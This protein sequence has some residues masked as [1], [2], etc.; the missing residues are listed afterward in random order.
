MPRRFYQRH[1]FDGSLFSFIKSAVL[2][3]FKIGGFVSFS[4]SAVLSHFRNRRFCLI[5]EI[6]GFDSFKIECCVLL[7]FNKY[8]QVQNT[9][10]NSTTFVLSASPRAALA[11][12]AVLATQ[13]LSQLTITII[14]D[15]I[16]I[17]MMKYKVFLPNTKLASRVDQLPVERVLLKLRYVKFITWKLASVMSSEI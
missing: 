4:K 1:N 8:L 7:P 11:G 17:W 16:Y 9:H 15:G 13:K 2:S 5:F 14:V 10:Y 3:H 12:M 6:G